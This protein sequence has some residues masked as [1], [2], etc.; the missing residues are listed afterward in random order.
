LFIDALI[1]P[2]YVR[3]LQNGTEATVG[4]HSH[5]KRYVKAGKKI[6]FL[7][8]ETRSKRT[9][10]ITPPGRDKRPFDPKERLDVLSDIHFLF[11]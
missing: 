10:A 9:I 5:C 11:M 7:D 6:R 4:R 1:Q 2:D 3:A 8:Y